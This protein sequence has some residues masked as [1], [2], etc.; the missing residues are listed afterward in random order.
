MRSRISKLEDAVRDMKR[1]SFLLIIL[2]CVASAAAQERYV[3]PVDEAKQEPSFYK[4]R[5]ELIAAAERHDAAFILSILDP[6]IELSFGG[7]AG[8]ADFKRI[9]KINSK[10]SPFWNEFLRVL[11]NGGSFTGKGA[12]KMFFAPY[13]FQSFPE[14]LDAFEHVVIF[15][16]DVNL[17]ERPD[18]GSPVVAALS[19]NIAKIDYEGSV[20]D[21]AD[22]G[23]LLWTKVETLGGKRGFVKSEYVRSP[24]DY[25]AGFQKKKGKWKMTVFI[26]GD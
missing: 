5:E 13:T 20:K 6:K 25:R 12:G 10:A 15:G 24:I 3:R 2:C 8:T 19:Y 9:W 18:L 11:K 14:D 4:F 1:V 21:P 16:S 22:E 23:V 17:R 26:A 7:D